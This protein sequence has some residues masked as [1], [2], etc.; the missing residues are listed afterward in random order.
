MD[1]IQSGTRN[2]SNDNAV[3]RNK[4]KIARKKGMTAGIIT[5][6]VISLVIILVVGA[7]AFSNFRKE[8]KT[9]FAVM[10]EQESAFNMQVTQRD[11]IINDW[12]VTFDQIEKDLNMI[13]EKE[14][15]L[16]VSSTDS[17]FSQT[18]RDQILNDIRYLNTLLEENKKKIASL[19]AQLNKSGGN[20]KALQ[21]RIAVLETNM[22]QYE[23]DIAGLK[24]TLVSKDFEIVQLN[25]QLTALEINVKEADEKITSQTNL[26]NEAFIAS[27][28]YKELKDKGIV[29]K[30]GGFLGLGRKESLTGDISDTLFVKIDV[31]ETKTIPVNSKNAKLIT[32]HPAGSYTLIHENDNLVSYIEINDPEAFWKISRYAVVEIMK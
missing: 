15:I 1:N 24:D 32:E 26:M 4:E 7:I 23:S 9:Q 19:T 3:I 22:K 11:S 17:E 29:L 28:T 18:R 21:S 8:Q 25:G 27:G 14:N 20:M 16:S 12:L 30:E 10:Q 6:S 2:L 31:R 5:T 13:K